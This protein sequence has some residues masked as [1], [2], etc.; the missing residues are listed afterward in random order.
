MANGSGTPPK[1]CVFR[2]R[3]GSPQVIRGLYCAVL[4]LVSLVS[5]PSYAW[6]RGGDVGGSPPTVHT[7]SVSSISLDKA[8]LNGEVNPNGLSAEAWFEYGTDPS[9]SRPIATAVQAIESAAKPRLFGIPISGLHRYT[10]Y[11]YRVVAST[12]AGTQRGEIRAFPTG[13]FYVVIGDSITQGPYGRGYAAI[14]KDLLQH[15]K[16]YPHTVANY[17]ISGIRSGEGARLISSTLASLPEAK[18]FLVLYGTNDASLFVRTRSGKGKISGD[19][20][21]RG[22]YKD[23]L[24]R[25]VS[26]ILAAGKV[27]YLAKVPYTIHR[28]YDL[29]RIRKYN[30][31][32]DELVVENR[33][34]AVPPDLF[35]YFMENPHEL[36]DGLHPGREGYSAIAKI[37][38]DALTGRCNT[39]PSRQTAEVCDSRAEALRPGA[40]NF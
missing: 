4:L 27:P 1:R 11:Y 28:S 10:T 29:S 31:V 7:R 3:N 12:G 30:E 32:I 16:G 13:E 6:S 36:V 5:F 39:P 17:G 37:W 33:I 2:I 21:Y 38:L 15:S 24:Q 23:N 9:L 22:S 18:Y 35:S 25:I 14:L 20:G 19:P 40:R 26:A 8:V 34:G